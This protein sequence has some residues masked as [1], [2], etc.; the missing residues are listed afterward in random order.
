VCPAMTALLAIVFGRTR[1]A[2]LS[3]F[4]TESLQAA[5]A[6]VGT[7]TFLDADAASEM[8]QYISHS[9]IDL[10]VE[11][12]LYYERTAYHTLHKDL[13]HTCAVLQSQDDV[14]CMA[15]V[16]Q[17]QL[18]DLPFAI[19]NRSRDARTRRRMPPM[20]SR[21]QWKRCWRHH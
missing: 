1:T 7:V 20:C 17:S 2:R 13:R 16:T 15:L 21:R 5:G 12:C 11:V 8:R 4:Y 3:A 19:R 6:E 9:H 14:Y 10:H 18:H